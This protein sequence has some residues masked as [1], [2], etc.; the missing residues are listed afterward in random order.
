M[1]VQINIA[2]TIID[3][4]SVA[5]SPQ[6][7]EAIIQFAQL[8]AEAL[9]ATVG[10]FDVVPQV[11]NID[12]YNPGV[13]IPLPNFTFPTTNVRGF[14]ATYTVFRTTSTTTVAE[15]G[16]FQAVYNP[17]GPTGSKWNMSQDRTG[18]GQISFSISDT[19]AISFTTLTLSGAN[20][21]GEISYSAK[22]ILQ[23]S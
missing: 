10:A 20:H 5:A 19:G 3:F 13:A 6:W 4:P 9:S 17:A 8:T 12:I 16:T 15:K 14:D 22:S 18:D 23:S 21:T 11:F 2:G 7:A 1:S